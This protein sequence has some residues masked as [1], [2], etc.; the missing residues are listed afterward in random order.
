MEGFGLLPGGGQAGKVLLVSCSSRK[1]RVPG[2]VPAKDL[3]LGTL[4]RL[5]LRLAR[6]YEMRAYILSAK[7]GVV[8]PTRLLR[9]YDQKLREPY[10]GPWPEGAGYYVGSQLYFGKA[11]ARFRRLLPLGLPIG[12][13]LAYLKKLIAEGL[14]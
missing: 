2:E 7:Y 6:R 11:P 1:R 4:L 5:A 12:K 8:E 10:D 9:Y 3:Y 13:Q 14:P